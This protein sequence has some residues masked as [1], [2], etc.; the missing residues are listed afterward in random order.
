MSNATQADSQH[1]NQANAKADFFAMVSGP[2]FVQPA[3]TN[4]SWEDLASNKYLIDSPD[5]PKDLPDP[6]ENLKVPA[7][8]TY[9]GQFV[10]HDLTFDT[11]SVF[12]GGRR[13][14]TSART[15]RFDLDCVYGAGPDASPYMYEDGV[16]LVARNNDLPRADNDRAIIGDPRNDENSIVCQI[17]MAFIRFHNAVVDRIK[18][19]HPN[20]KKADLFKKAQ[21][22]VRWTYQK[23]LVEDYLPRIV[24]STDISK[25]DKLRGAGPTGKSTISGAFKL[26]PDTPATSTSP[27]ARSKIP[28]EFAAAAYRF[29]HSM[30]RNGYRLNANTQKHIFS[31]SG[32]DSLVGFGELPASHLID[33][34]LFFPNPELPTQTTSPKPPTSQVK[35]RS[36]EPGQHDEKNQAEGRDRLQYAYKIDPL[37]VDPLAHL[38]IQVAGTGEP[39]SLGFRNLIRGR[40]FDLPSGQEVA[41][42]A[43]IPGLNN[44]KLL[45][46]DKVSVKNKQTLT[47]IPKEFQTNTP[48]WLYILIEAH[49]EVVNWYG[50]AARGT[51]A[52]K[53]F[54]EDELTDA[55]SQTTTQLTGVGA[56]IVLETFHGL[57]D[58]DTE[59]YRH[60][61]V[62]TWEP[63][64]KH[65]RMW[66]LV[67]CNLK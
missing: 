33:W 63:L 49:Q 2:V 55:A 17:Q 8:Y 4:L 37:L 7:G 14:F 32:P 22:E 16:R 45:A 62:S 28:L 47:L 5:T 11:T 51:N 48:L 57:L 52:N 18:Q 21:Q 67:N 27:A 1:G 13:G 43:G 56:R 31:P 61:P 54:T 34:S 50:S 44:L 24:T 36:V 29:G 58:S 3:A 30:V 46:R 12:G 39:Q 15:P 26:Y 64:I 20:I 59:S 10:D 40:G 19:Q 66:D 38:P 53:P 23:I 9:F 41:K 65:F 35:S 42:V 60:T 25:F 6:E